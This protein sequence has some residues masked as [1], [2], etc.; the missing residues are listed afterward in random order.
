MQA[1]QSSQAMRARLIA[2]MIVVL[3]GCGSGPLVLHPPE[4]TPATARTMGTPVDMEPIARRARGDTMLVPAP[5]APPGVEAVLTS[6]MSSEL[7][8][9]A[10]R[11]GEPGGYVVRCTLDRFAIRWRS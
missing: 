2:L 7:R 9:R 10:L 6:G 3:S 1:K 11:G 4:C 8:A 5:I